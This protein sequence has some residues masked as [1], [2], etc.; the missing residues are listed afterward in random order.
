MICFESEAEKI[1]SNRMWQEAAGADLTHRTIPL[2]RNVHRL[3]YHE[4]AQVILRP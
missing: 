4:P 3:P 1:Q 2:N